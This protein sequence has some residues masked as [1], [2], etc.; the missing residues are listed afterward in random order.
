[1]H[2]FKRSN[3]LNLKWSAAF[4]NAKALIEDLNKKK[5]IGK[6]SPGINILKKKNWRINIQKII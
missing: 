5:L 3:K 6:N 4:S 1:M 2:S